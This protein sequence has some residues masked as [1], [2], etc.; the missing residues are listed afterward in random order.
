V[1]KASPEGWR[2]Y[3][4]GMQLDL[5]E[6]D[7]LDAAFSRLLDEIDHQLAAMAAQKG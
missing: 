5:K 7:S 6:G 1:P 3:K 2:A 4:G